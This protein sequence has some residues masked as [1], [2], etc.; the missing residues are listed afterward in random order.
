MAFP[1]TALGI[2]F[3]ALLDTGWTDI[4]RID[5]DTHVLGLDGESGISVT[6][7]ISNEQNR[8]NPTTINLDYLDNNAT[9]DGDNPYSTYYRKIGQETPV[10]VV[11]TEFEI[12]EDF[13]DT[14]YNITLVNGVSDADWA[15]SST[16]SYEGT[17]SL[18]SGTI[19]DGQTSTVEFAVPSD[20]NEMSFWYWLSSE[21]DFD[22]FTVVVSYVDGSVGTPFEASGQPLE[23]VYKSIDLSYV[24]DVQF[25]YSKDSSVS[26]GE[27]AV[28]IDKLV[29]KHVRATASINSITPVWDTT[30]NRT[31]AAI[32]ALGYLKTLEETSRPI[33]SVATRAIP[34]PVNSEQLIA[35]WPLEEE[36]DASFFASTTGADSPSTSGSLTIGSGSSSPST[37]RMISFGTDGQMFFTVPEYSSDE[38]K[39]TTLWNYPDNGFAANTILMRL[40]CYGGSAAFIDIRTGGANTD[41]LEVLAYDSSNVLIDATATFFFTGLLMGNGFLMSV[42]LVDDGADTDMVL[43]I[44]DVNSDTN[45]TASETLVGVTIGR[46]GNVVLGED[47]ISGASIGQLA[48]ANNVEALE[49]FI[50]PIDT[51]GSLGFRAFA[52]E[53]AFERVIRLLYEE[54]IPFDFYGNFSES[55]A[56]GPQSSGKIL[57]LIY[58]AIDVDRG[59]LLESRASLSVVYLAGNNLYNRVPSFQLTYASPDNTLSHPFLPTQ[60][61]KALTNIVT[62]KREMGSEA[63]YTI[64]DGD[65]MHYSTEPTYEGGANARPGDFTLNVEADSQLIH[66][67][68]WTAHLSAWR[69]KR[70]TSMNVQLQR[71]PFDDTLRSQVR[72]SEIGD[73]TWV[74][75]TGTPRWLPYDEVRLSLR[76]YT[77]ILA[78]FVHQFIYNTVPADPYEVEVVDTGGSTLAFAIDSDDTSIKLATSLGP[79]WSTVDEPYHIQVAGQPMTVTSITT[80]TITFI[81]AG[82]SV[83]A[84]N[85]AGTST[86]APG[87]H[88]STAAGDTVLLVATIRNSGTGTVNTPSGW[89][90]LAGA[91]TNAVLFGKV[92]TAA[93]VA[94]GSVTVSFTGGVANAT[95]TGG[96]ATWRSASLTHGGGLTND[97][98][99]KQTP[100]GNSQLNGSATNIAYP[101]LQVVRDGCLVVVVGWRQDDYT[102]IATLGG[103]TEVDEHS[104]T[105]GDDAGHI[106]DYVI[107]TTATDIASGSFTV[108]T[109]GGAAISRAMVVALRPLQTATV[110]RGIAGVATSAAVGA[111]IRSWRSGVNGL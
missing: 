46:I 107:Q 108:T 97:D 66:Q 34:S 68:A 80:D 43:H 44:A 53:M 84:A 38:H 25:V 24:T 22:F 39:V 94:T 55:H 69:E 17:W 65:V 86:I 52:G 89:T 41:D 67:A 70:I 102:S 27:D 23:W 72:A 105:G 54:G 75:T 90:V 2:G 73:T 104:E 5:D 16:R 45:S 19:T 4:T 11:L 49:N 47:N 33:A 99:A 29:F 64:P 13:E 26:F 71:E 1:D 56:M 101:A 6:R 110:T 103:M 61:N 106:W 82:T 48:V 8:T 79:E 9:L 12:E 14:N 7:G 74:D 35:H 10:R 15:R 100:T 32:E 3:E 63:T 77:E 85:A 91:G 50:S 78:Q 76:G 42:E 51:N 59:L 60:D 62:A 98:I 95:L 109:G 21:E 36:S 88:A 87:F 28:W 83:G 92:V 58:E 30:G 57:E 18:K 96:T 37:D 81:G 93:E 111:A 20:V 40:Y 31:V